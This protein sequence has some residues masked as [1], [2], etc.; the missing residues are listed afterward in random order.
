MKHHLHSFILP[1][2]LILFI[3][4]QPIRNNAI[5]SPRSSSS[6][7]K[8]TNVIKRRFDHAPTNNKNHPPKEEEEEE[9][10]KMKMRGGACDSDATMFIK[11]LPNVILQSI[12]LY[13]VLLAPTTSSNFPLQDFYPIKNLPFIQYVSIFVVIFASSLVSSAV[14]GTLSAA[15]KQVLDPNVVP[16]GETG[17]YDSLNRPKWEP[18]GFVFPIMWLIVSKPTQFIAVSRMMRLFSTQKKGRRNA[19]AAMLVYCIHLSLGDLWNKVFFG[20]QCPGRGV[21][22]IM[23]FWGVLIASAGLFWRLEKEAGLFLIPTI[24]WVGIASALNWFIYLNN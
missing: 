17:W 19:A 4:Q 20:Y 24:C 12:L 22:V 8:R 1:L 21:V 10:M 18:P 23:A 5:I 9:V 14:D 16:G 2:F 7:L 3:L 13:F 6:F 11:L 15:S